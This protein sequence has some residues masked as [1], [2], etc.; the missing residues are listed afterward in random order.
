MGSKWMTW[1]SR[2]GV[3]EVALSGN[4]GFVP[5][6]E[7]LR[8][9]ARAG[10]KGAVEIQGDGTSGRI[11]FTRKG[12]ALAT[13]RGDDDLRSHLINTQYVDS[14][15]LAEAEAG[16]PALKTVADERP[17]FV[18]LLREMTV[19]SI[20]Q[21]SHNG[22]TFEV[23]EDA[24]TPYATP[25]PF[26]LEAILSDSAKRANEWAEVE[27]LLS[28]M[29]GVIRMKRDLGDRTE[30]TVSHD[31]WKLLSELGSGSSVS[32]MASR[33]GTTEF[34][35]AK[36]AS[37]LTSRELLTIVSSDFVKP[38]ADTWEMPASPEVE[39]ELVEDVATDEDSHEGTEEVE[40]DAGVSFV[41]DGGTADEDA[42]PDD[43]PEVAAEAAEVAEEVAE[44]QVVSE[45]FAAGSDAEQ[46]VATEDA[47][48]VDE[49]DVDPNESWWVEPD[50]KS[51]KTPAA[52]HS[53]DDDEDDEDEGR[54]GRLGMFSPSRTAA[55]DF[56]PV[57]GES[58]GDVEEDTEAF[59]EK[60]FSQ[61]EEPVAET[62]E[63][64]AG[65]D[66]T[67]SETE[68]DESSGHGLLRRRRLGSIL[69][70]STKSND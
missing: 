62:T 38:S 70:D 60:V 16:K 69:T 65:E 47:G 52:Q 56:E 50:G 34:W 11:F 29:A 45:V 1:I 19:E 9:L 54:R 28:D 20:Y 23:D 55:D 42:D 43:S 8:L 40:S 24:V 48:P 59:L 18:A 31:A 46:P 64:P 57:T 12:I 49:E 22:A 36:V 39:S 13:T 26:E 3:A 41:E 35:T 53:G 63:S 27:E 14:D 25:S 30:V 37:D 15:Q 17:E 21:L 5:L 44:E 4:L 7:V 2:Q 61:L 32:E 66:E 6:D 10:Q 67:E 51:A 68:E 58:N 33:L